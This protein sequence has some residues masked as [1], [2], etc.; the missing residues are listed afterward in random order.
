M[1]TLISGNE[2][3]LTFMYIMH[4]EWKDFVQDDMLQKECNAI[5]PIIFRKLL[6]NEQV[7]KPSIFNY[8]IEYNGKHVIYNTMY[9]TLI[10]L[11]PLEFDKLNGIRKAGRK[12]YKNFL[13]N[14]LLVP[15]YLDEFQC[16]RAWREMQYRHLN[17]L[18]LNITTT[19]Q[20]NARCSYCY[21]TGVIQEGF[22]KQQM[23]KLVSF[24]K[25]HK[26][27]T[28]VLLNWFGGE[29]L[30]NSALMDCISDDL[31]KENIKFVSYIITNGS[32]ITKKMVKE[33]F[34][35]W[36]VHDVQITLD[37]TKM[38]YEAR[39]AYLSK[40]KNIFE[41]ILKNIQILAD[42]DILVHIRLNTDCDNQEDILKLLDILHE[43]FEDA[44][45]IIYYPAFLTG[46]ES[47]LTDSEKI[48]FIKKIFRALPN[49]EK[50]HI[51]N[52]MYS[53]PKI[54]PCMR[55]DP[56]SYSIDIHGRIYACE[57]FVGRKE[58]SIGTLSRMRKATALQRLEDFSLSDECQTCVFLP[59]CMGGC[60]A[61]LETGDSTCMIEKYMIQAYMEYLCE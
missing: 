44:Q 11:T 42:N 59:K 18:S 5:L 16:Y 54:Y 1:N 49:P 13:E 33:K 37:G 60:V 48:S 19:L 43:K 58:H 45:N 8:H 9:N 41:R 25:R 17:H 28:P 29:P 24:I 38:V 3:I 56:C 46:I 12:L 52:R 36:Q 15:K 40:P 26:K 50:M 39:K 47:K 2:K 23:P 7:T 20:C 27:D 30:M 22:Q 6:A 31:K 57:H 21:E 53:Y 35:R 32:L 51:G 55:N 34:K 61:N 4:P 10:M 14:G